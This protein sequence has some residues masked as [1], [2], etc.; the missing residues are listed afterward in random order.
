MSEPQ[1]WSDCAVH[2]A[3]ALK[4]EPCDC[5]GYSDLTDDHRHLLVTPPV[6]LSRSVG[7]GLGKG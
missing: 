4:P 3:P 1:H 2:N 6:A 5:G 7:G